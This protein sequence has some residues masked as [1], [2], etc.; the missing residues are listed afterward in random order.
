MQRLQLLLHKYWS[1]EE[2]PELAELALANCGTVQKRGELAKAVAPLNLEP[3]Q[4]LV[5]RQLG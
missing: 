2:F 1:A 4:L 3:L 5:C